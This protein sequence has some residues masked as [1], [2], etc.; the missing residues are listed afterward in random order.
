[1]LE[2]GKLLLFDEY[3]QDAV[4]FEGGLLFYKKNVII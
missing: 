2:G 3:N 4:L 1:M